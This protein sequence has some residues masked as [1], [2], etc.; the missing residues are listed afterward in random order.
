M[1]KFSRV[2]GSRLLSSALA[3]VI[4]GALCFSVGEGLRLT[5]FPVSTA[6]QTADLSVS[7]THEKTS[8][9]RYGPLDV[10]SQN[11]KRSK[12]QLLDLTGPVLAGTPQV[13]PE[14][15]AASENDATKAPAVLFVA[16]PAGRAPPFLF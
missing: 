14:W 13:D 6:T 11:Q 4:V 2:M 9:L 10:P 3:A 15:S 5:P 8:R 12:R 1:K 16:R 7:N